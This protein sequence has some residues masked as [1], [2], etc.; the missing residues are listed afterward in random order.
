MS[1]GVSSVAGEGYL[2]RI[3]LRK[4]EVFLRQ[5]N[6]AGTC[7]SYLPLRGGNM[8]PFGKKK[9]ICLTHGK[10]KLLNRRN[11]RKDYRTWYA[12]TCLQKRALLRSRLPVQRGVMQSLLSVGINAKIED[13]YRRSFFMPGNEEHWNSFANFACSCNYFL[14]DTS[15]STIQHYMP[16]FTI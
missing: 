15:H 9:V 7:Y 8:T 1:L 16:T 13:R 11:S 12:S 6:E 14:C 4:H 2:E 5:Q 3:Y 10:K